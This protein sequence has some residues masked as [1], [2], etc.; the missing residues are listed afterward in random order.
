MIKYEVK[1]SH[2]FSEHLGG[3][4]DFRPNFCESSQCSASL[5][6]DNRINLIYNLLRFKMSS[7]T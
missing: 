5:K 1:N 4:G 2:Q 3:I 7:Y 6:D